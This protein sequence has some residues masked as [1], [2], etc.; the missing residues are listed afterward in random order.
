MFD[1]SMV[2]LVLLLLC[3]LSGVSFSSSVFTLCLIVVILLRM[4]WILRMNNHTDSDKLDSNA[5]ELG[6][7]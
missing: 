1:V 7:T 6:D 5:T 3:C 4:A 2:N